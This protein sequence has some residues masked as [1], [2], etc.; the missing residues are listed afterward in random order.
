LHTSGVS[1]EKIE[2]VPSWRASGLYSPLERLAMEYAE[3]MCDT[4]PTVGDDLVAQLREYLDEAQLV[5]LTAVVCL[6]NMR[7]RFNSAIGLPPQGF[8]ERCEL[9]PVATSVAAR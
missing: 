6:E 7:S 2:A 5:E 8:K 1:T 9:P 3:A 4:P